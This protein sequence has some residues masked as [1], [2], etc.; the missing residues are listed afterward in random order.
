[1]E[2]ECWHCKGP[3]GH[4]ELYREGTDELEAERKAHHVRGVFFRC[5]DCWRCGHETLFVDVHPL[6]GEPAAEFAR[7]KG[8]LEATV[9]QLQTEGAD[10][11]LQEW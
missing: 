9:R 10:V 5:Y 7:R 2:R 8:R 6:D 1:M 3:L 11:Q 4:A